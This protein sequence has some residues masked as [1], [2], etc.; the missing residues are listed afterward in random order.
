MLEAMACGTPVVASRASAL[1]EIAGDAALYAP[2]DDADAWAAALQRVVGDAPLRE[3]LR[4]EG[5]RRAQLF[6][7]DESARQHLTLFQS[8]AG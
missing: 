7:W 8:V 4:A 3:R 6:S 5:F 2:S 1:P